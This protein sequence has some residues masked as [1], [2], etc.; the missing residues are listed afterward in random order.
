MQS[1]PRLAIFTHLL[2]ASGA[3]IAGQDGLGVD[4][5]TLQAGDRFTHLHQLVI[6]AGQSPHAVTL[7]L[8]DPRTG[9]RW[10]TDQDTDNVNLFT[11]E[12]QP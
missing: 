11:L 6:P 5:Y 12:E 2:D 7:G 4:P 1:G 3:Y 9:E 8:Y 10:R